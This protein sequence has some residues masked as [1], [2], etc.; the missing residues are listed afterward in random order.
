MFKLGIINYMYP[1]YLVCYD[2]FTS[3]F[4]FRQESGAKEAESIH[5]RLLSGVAGHPHHKPCL[6]SGE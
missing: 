2:C 1:P 3:C 4:F 6:P 5:S